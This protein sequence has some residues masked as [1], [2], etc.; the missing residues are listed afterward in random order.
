MSLPLIKLLKNFNA[1]KYTWLAKI[2]L[3]NLANRTICLIN[4]F[5]ES[6][7]QRLNKHEIYHTVLSLKLCFT[8]IC[9]EFI[10]IQELLLFKN[11]AKTLD[12]AHCE[13]ACTNNLSKELRTLEN[14]LQGGGYV[15]ARLWPRNVSSL[16]FVRRRALHA[17]VIPVEITFPEVESHLARMIAFFERYLK[18]RIRV[19]EY[20]RTWTRDDST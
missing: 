20:T 5:I 6:M 2:D 9:V 8:N 19:H 13:A 1:I 10:T 7:E 15:V 18:K 12:L 16:C 4:L 17:K 11:K 14:D 3:K